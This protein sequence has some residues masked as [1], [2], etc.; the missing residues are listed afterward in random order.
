MASIGLPGSR[1]SLPQG[2]GDV[3]RQRA[4][5]HGDDPGLGAEAPAQAGAC[6]EPVRAGH[7]YVHEHDV[8]LVR[9]TASSAAWPLSA[10]SAR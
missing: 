6:R 7:L 9:A 4:F 8:V 2:T 1:P 10:V 3:G 5:R